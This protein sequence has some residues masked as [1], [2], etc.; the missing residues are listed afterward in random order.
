MRPQRRAWLAF[1][2][3]GA[4]AC[5]LWGARP[6]QDPTDAELPEVSAGPAVPLGPGAQEWLEHYLSGFQMRLSPQ[7]VR[8]TAAA[9]ISESERNGLDRDI[10]LAVIRVE[11][12]FNAF[13]RSH[14]GALG[15]MQ[16]MPYTGEVVARNIGVE[17]SGPESL[18]DPVT[19]VR[20]GTAYLA[21]LHARYNDMD[22]ALAAYNWGPGA[23]DRRLRLGSPMPEKYVTQ[24]STA[25][26]QRYRR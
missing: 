21:E 23:I 11:S 10:V 5:S 22:R 18:Y 2:L 15:L 4:L 26:E 14:M 7:E 20:I 8:L 3:V 24:V 13:A 16:V 19:N 12:G 25:L 9:I 1:A 6:V 17:W